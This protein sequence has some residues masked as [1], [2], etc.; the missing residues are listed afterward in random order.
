MKQFLTLITL[1]V[2]SVLASI[3]T[4][5]DILVDHAWI[6]AMP[7]TSRVVPVYLTLHNQS[8]KPISL[9]AITSDIGVIELHQSIKENNMMRMEPVSRLTLSAGQTVKLAPGS[10]HGMLSHFAQGVPKE[11]SEVPIT[12]IFESDN[13]IS[14]VASVMKSNSSH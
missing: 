10:Y 7:P 3:A 12:L 8:D 5:G 4:A 11:G 1:L 13:K 2:A 9:V 14:T 6:R